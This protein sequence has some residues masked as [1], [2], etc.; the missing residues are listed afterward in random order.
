MSFDR[1]FKKEFYSKVLGEQ[2]K[3]FIHIPGKKESYPVIY[4]L[5]AQAVGLYREALTITGNGIMTGPHIIVGLVTSG[6]RNRDM[7]PVEISSRPGSGGAKEFLEFITSELQPYVDKKFNTN[8]INIL[9]GGSNA[10]LFTVYAM[11]E[12][13]EDFTGFISSSTMIGHCSEFMTDK[14]KQLQPDRLEGKY[15]FIHYGLKGEYDKAQKYIPDYYTLLTDRFGDFLISGIRPEK[16]G[17]HV[18]LGGIA[19]GLEFIYH[20]LNSESPQ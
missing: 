14:A 10:G 11:L 2:R 1:V 17:G 3:L 12:S 13:P 9:Y 7:I 16:N 15:L 5:D 19:S 6:S 18:P 4:L 20:H 8:G